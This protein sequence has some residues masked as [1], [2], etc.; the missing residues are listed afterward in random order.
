MG[1]KHLEFYCGVWRKN[2]EH[3]AL[4]ANMLEYILGSRGR[5]D[6]DGCSRT[7]GRRNHSKESPEGISFLPFRPV[8]IQPYLGAQ[9]SDPYIN[10]DRH[11]FLKMLAVS[12]GF[13]LSC[14]VPFI[15]SQS[16][17][18]LCSLLVYYLSRLCDTPHPKRCVNLP[19]CFS[20][21]TQSRHMK[22]GGTA[23]RSLN[24]HSRWM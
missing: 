4:S 21:T 6:L 19:Q 11:E 2:S 8:L 22:S 20:N 13:L 3:K 7:H 24:L 1:L 17:W 16:C 12:T 23:R 5:V 18:N 14:N 9:F 15:V 10:T